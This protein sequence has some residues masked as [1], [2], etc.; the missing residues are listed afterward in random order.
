MENNEE[1]EFNQKLLKGLYQAYQKML[2]FKRYKK[3]KVVVSRDGKI[4]HLEP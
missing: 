1:N 4:L 2:E 3:N